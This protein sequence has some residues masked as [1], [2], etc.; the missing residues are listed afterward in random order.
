VILGK[1]H[2]HAIALAIGMV[3]FDTSA[4]ALSE[5]DLAHGVQAAQRA[6]YVSALPHFQ[7]LAAQGHPAAQYNLAMLYAHGLG[8]PRDATLAT[9]WAQKSAASGY[10][11]AIDWLEKSEQ[12]SR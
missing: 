7:V 4:M 6:D 12:S 5:P 2:Y 8:V 11:L 10:A 9:H 1:T 3:L